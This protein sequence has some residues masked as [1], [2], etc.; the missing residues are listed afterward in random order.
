MIDL[1]TMEAHRMYMLLISLIACIR[2]L[3]ADIPRFVPREIL[4]RI[5]D[6]A[7]IKGHAQI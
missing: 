4:P 2:L 7:P 5:V 6:P 1:P 3:N